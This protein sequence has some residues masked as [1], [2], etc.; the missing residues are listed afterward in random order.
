MLWK[1]IRIVLGVLEILGNFLGWSVRPGISFLVWGQMLEP[2]LCIYTSYFFQSTLCCQSA[3]ET[4]TE[5][6]DQSTS[7]VDPGPDRLVG[8]SL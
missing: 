3:V 5:N 4:G 8:G 1:F 6:H 2:R 7:S